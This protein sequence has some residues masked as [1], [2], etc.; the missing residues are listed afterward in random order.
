M[1]RGSD[2]DGSVAAFRVGPLATGAL[3]LQPT[4]GAGVVQT[5]GIAVIPAAG[6]ERRVYFV[7]NANGDG[8]LTFDYVAIDDDGLEDPTPATVT[9]EVAQVNDPPDARDVTLEIDE[10]Q[11]LEYPR[12]LFNVVDVDGDLTT[13]ELVS[14]PAHAASFVLRPDGSFRYLPPRDFNGEDAFT[15]RAS[16][17]KGGFDEGTVTI[18]VRPVDEPGID[19][20]GTGGRDVFAGT[21]QG[22]TLRGLGGNDVLQGRGETTRSSA[23]PATTR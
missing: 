4:G 20:T 10:D 2:P 8:S 14:G 1:L 6:N 15:Y 22:D 17:G 13:A 19:W 11:P 3:Y 23:A 9:L 18:V 16:D 7:P 12:R 21:D 5:G